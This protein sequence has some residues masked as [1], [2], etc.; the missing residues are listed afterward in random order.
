MSLQHVREPPSACQACFLISKH[1]STRAVC[2]I[3]GWHKTDI[4]LLWR[5]FCPCFPAVKRGFFLSNVAY[6]SAKQ[7]CTVLTA[8]GAQKRDLI[9]P[10]LGSLSALQR[11][12]PTSQT[13]PL[14]QKYPQICLELSVSVFHT[15]NMQLTQDLFG[16]ELLLF[17]VKRE[18]GLCRTSSF[19][20]RKS[21]NKTGG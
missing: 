13:Q 3:P 12:T 16:L 4:N 14:A 5:S 11:P 8:V 9:Q 7:P 15:R 17:K 10:R 2:T 19:T 21:D 6:G 1:P 18:K 20:F